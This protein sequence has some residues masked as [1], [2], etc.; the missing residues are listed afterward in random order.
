MS[1]SRSLF[2][3]LLSYSG[4][5]LHPAGHCARQDSAAGHPLPRPHQ[6]VQLHHVSLVNCNTDVTGFSFW[7]WR[8]KIITVRAEKIIRTKPRHNWSE[9]G[10]CQLTALPHRPQPLPQFNPPISSARI[11]VSNAVTAMEVWLLACMMLV[12][13]SLVEY[14]IILR[15]SVQH[16]RVLEKMK[17]EPSHHPRSSNGV[18]YWKD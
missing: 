9:S 13:F 7:S 4:L 12:F 18:W 2:S 6:H 8:E 17:K 14:T 3:Y 11:P 5:L 16:N 15:K 10:L 1:R